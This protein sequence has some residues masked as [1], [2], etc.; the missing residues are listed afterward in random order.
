MNIK[1]ECVFMI[2]HPSKIIFENGIPV[3]ILPN[4]YEVQ[5]V[6][7]SSVDTFYGGSKVTYDDV[8]KTILA[9]QNLSNFYKKMAMEVLEKNIYLDSEANLRIYYQNM[10]GI[11]VEVLSNEQMQK[12]GKGNY[13]LYD[14]EDNTIYVLEA[15]ADYELLIQHE[16][17][18]AFHTLFDKE[19]GIII[20]EEKGIALEEA[21]TEEIIGSNEE[22]PEL[23]KILKFLIDNVDNFNYHAYNCY[24]IAALI[25][26]LKE[27]YPSIDID[28]LIEY[29]DQITEYN[30]ENNEMIK[31]C[32]NLEFIEQCFNIVLANIDR[33]DISFAFNTFSKLFDN[34]NSEILNKYRELYNQRLKQMEIEKKSLKM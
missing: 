4:E 29:M 15:Y 34:Q 20:S 30:S 2:K 18:H 7:R 13:A 8:V 12:K 23:R 26:E 28:K 24:G 14:S 22:Y 16:L 10:F 11:K 6:N 21:I 9:N 5:K 1:K 27:K 17:N 3:V 32:D 25:S 19:K 33:D 31:I